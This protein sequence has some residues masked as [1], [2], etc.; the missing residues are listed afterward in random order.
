[1]VI[2]IGFTTSISDHLSFFF[3]YITE[4]DDYAEIVDEEPDYAHPMAGRFAVML[5]KISLNTIFSEGYLK[6]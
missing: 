3:I 1:M 5:G 6:W 2:Y 4:F